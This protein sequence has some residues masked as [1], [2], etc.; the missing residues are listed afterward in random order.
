[1]KTCFPLYF[2]LISL[3]LCGCRDAKKYHDENP[4]IKND[5]PK[6]LLADIRQFQQQLNESF[7]DPDSSPLSDKERQDFEGL[8][9]FRADTAF[10]VLARLER[11][12]ES[13]PFLMPTTTD[14]KST[15]RVFGIARFNIADRDFELEVYQNLELLSEEGYENYLFLPFTDKTNG[16]S[17]Y[18]GGR[19]IDL[20]IPVGDELVI[21]FN[22]AYNPYCVYNEKYSCPIVPGVNDLDTEILAGLKDYKKKEP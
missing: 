3:L 1:M 16:F 6:D 8:E 2:F 18:A 9:F 21:D 4:D 15:E 22:R 14:R 12:P 19:Y 10:R 20:E 17:T 11:T 5:N 7:Y 13:L